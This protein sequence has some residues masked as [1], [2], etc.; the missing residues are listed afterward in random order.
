[1]VQKA[2]KKNVVKVQQQVDPKE[3]KLQIQE[4][5]FEG[6]TP[7]NFPSKEEWLRYYRDR[8][9]KTFEET[10]KLYGEATRLP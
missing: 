5:I 1:M 4:Y 8:A 7:S 6:K 2:K 3:A 9:D 10:S